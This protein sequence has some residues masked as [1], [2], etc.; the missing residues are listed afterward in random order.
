MRIHTYSI[1]PVT[2]MCMRPPLAY[3]YYAPSNIRRRSAR[4]RVRRSRPELYYT[5]PRTQA[6]WY[7]A[8]D[9]RVGAVTDGDAVVGEGD[10]R[11]QWQE[12]LDA[13]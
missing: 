8:R 2:H 12:V 13:I 4:M 11:N 9:R 10:E 1:V 6:A 3:L 7:E 5:K